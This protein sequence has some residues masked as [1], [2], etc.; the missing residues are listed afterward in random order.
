MTAIN[1]D[2]WLSALQAAEIPLE[3]EQDAVSVIEFAAM[4]GMARHAAKKRLEEL[5][6]RG[7]ARQTYKWTENNGRRAHVKAFV[8]V[9]P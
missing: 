7:L 6:T 3:D 2:E 1:R 5:V 9:K 8:L 4:I